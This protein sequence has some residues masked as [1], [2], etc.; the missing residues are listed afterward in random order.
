MAEMGNEVTTPEGADYDEEGLYF[1]LTIL[2]TGFFWV[3]TYITYQF[4]G[5]QGV[6]ILG[7]LVGF[8]R[9]RQIIRDRKAELKINRL[10]SKLSEKTS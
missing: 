7:A 1:L 10:E 2:L 4:Y 9:A 6:C 3:M 8:V 5:W